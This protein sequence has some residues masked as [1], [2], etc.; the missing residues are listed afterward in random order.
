[1]TIKATIFGAAIVALLPAVSFADDRSS[2]LEPTC[3]ATGSGMDPRCVGQTQA[4][5]DTDRTTEAEHHAIHGVTSP[6]D[7]PVS[8]RTAPAR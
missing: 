7:H 2:N 3:Q 1:M 4:G 6:P 8:G 5:T